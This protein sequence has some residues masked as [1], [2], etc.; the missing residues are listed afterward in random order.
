MKKIIIG[1]GIGTLTVLVI[2]FIVNLVGIK[3][4][5]P[6]GGI[7]PSGPM[8]ATTTFSSIS[9]GPLN[10]VEIATSSGRI[11]MEIR[12]VDRGDTCDNVF[13]NFEDTEVAKVNYG[14]QLRAT[15]TDATG[16]F[17]QYII[18]QDNLYTGAINAITT[19]AASSTIEIIEAKK[20]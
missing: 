8:Y 9:I 16:R 5:I 6:T 15:S 14:V 11:Y 13:L 20:S 12:N 19:C 4:N 2:L 7:Y 3:T 18:N 17:S 1:T 10:S